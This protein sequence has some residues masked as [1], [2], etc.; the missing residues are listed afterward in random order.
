MHPYLKLGGYEHGGG[1]DELQHLPVDWSLGQVVVCHLDRQV[2]SLVVQLKVLL[3]KCVKQDPV[4]MQYKQKKLQRQHGYQ[5]E[6]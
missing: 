6:L 5:E 4:N 1:A 2:Q 3:T